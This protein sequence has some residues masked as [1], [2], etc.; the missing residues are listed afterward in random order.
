M[1]AVIDE[2][3]ISGVAIDETLRKEGAILSYSQKALIKIYMNQ[4]AN[5]LCNLD[6]DVNNVTAFIQQQAGL[7]GELQAYQFLLD[8]SEAAETEAR[9]LAMRNQQENKQQ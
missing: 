3:I 5:E 1:K 7:K 9:D 6:V 4:A 8:S 2:V